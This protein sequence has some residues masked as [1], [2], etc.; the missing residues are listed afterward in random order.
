MNVA[1]DENED[2]KNACEEMDFSMIYDDIPFKNRLLEFE[3]ERDDEAIQKIYN[4]VAKAREFLFNLDKQ[5]E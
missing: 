5:L 4:N 3:I 2:Y 1:T